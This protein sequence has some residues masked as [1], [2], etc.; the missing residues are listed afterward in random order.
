MTDDFA[1]KVIDHDV[2]MSRA[3]QTARDILLRHPPCLTNAPVN[4]LIEDI[5]D[6][7]ARPPK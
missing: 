2:A 7:I 6:A 5:A 4:D 3:R 1:L